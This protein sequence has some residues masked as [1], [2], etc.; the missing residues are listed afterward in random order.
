MTITK[1][2]KDNNNNNNNANQIDFDNKY[3]EYFDEQE[4]N[5]NNNFDWNYIQKNIKHLCVVWINIALVFV[6]CLFLFFYFF[7]FNYMVIRDGKKA[8]K[9]F[10][11]KFSILKAFS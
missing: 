7:V 3:I 6:W 4:M 11:L 1:P 2:Q 8:Q 10:R 9:Y 5:F